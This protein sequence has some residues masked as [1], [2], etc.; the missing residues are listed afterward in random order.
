MDNN[1]YKKYKTE[2]HYYA[3]G[4]IMSSKEYYSF[5]MIRMKQIDYFK[6]GNIHVIRNFDFKERLHKEYKRYNEKGVLELI[7]KY[8]HGKINHW[9]EYYENGNIE[10]DTNY[11]NGKK[12]GM[13]NK[14]S[15][16]KTLISTSQYLND[17][18]IANKLYSE[19]VFKNLYKFVYLISDNDSRRGSDYNFPPQNNIYGIGCKF[20]LNNTHHYEIT[21]GSITINT[22]ILTFVKS[23]DF[24][25]RELTFDIDNIEY[26]IEKWNENNINKMHGVAIYPT[27]PTQKIESKFAYMST[28]KEKPIAQEHVIQYRG[29][30][31][32]Y[33]MLY[34]EC[35]LYVIADSIEE[36]EIENEYIK[37]YM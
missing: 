11:S 33:I 35:K 17:R 7:I 30:N 37:N 25:V 2:N 21:K 26:K 29:Y 1:L 32:N 15:V 24:R 23:K 8:E 13:S 3:N 19:M 12:C 20:V 18:V 14:Y 16:N 31:N 9:K 36:L 5:G 10:E 22:N 34:K 4:I 6:N 27:K 28:K